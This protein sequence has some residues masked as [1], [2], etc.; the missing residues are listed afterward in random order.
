LGDSLLVLTLLWVGD[1]RS[2]QL[3]A[4]RIND[5]LLYARA[6]AQDGDTLGAINVLARLDGCEAKRYLLV[7]KMA[8]FYLESAGEML[9]DT[10]CFSERDVVLYRAYMLDFPRHPLADSLKALLPPLL[11]P[12]KALLINL[13]P[14]AGLAYAGR[15]WQGL[16]TFAAVAVGFAGITYSLK[17]RHY[18]DAAIWYFFWENRFLIGSFQ[19]TLSAVWEENRR[20]LRPY[21]AEIL[22]RLEEG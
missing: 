14:G 8:K 19:N 5:S 1:G 20:R 18:V 11:D 15:P 7:L 12:Q 16:K 3:E 22:R 2:A 9:K 6:L 4:L 21:F 13:I 10:T 17:K